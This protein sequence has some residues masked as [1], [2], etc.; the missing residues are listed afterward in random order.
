MTIN[1]PVGFMPSNPIF[2]GGP[3]GGGVK[4]I[5]LDIAVQVTESLIRNYVRKQ[6]ENAKKEIYQ[7]GTKGKNWS[8]T[9]R[10][11]PK[12]NRI[13]YRSNKAGY[14]RKFRRS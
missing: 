6:I 10:Y 5:I 8:K 1:V 12:H 11:P 3:S 2:I 9:R 14:Y 13:R 7:A 4:A